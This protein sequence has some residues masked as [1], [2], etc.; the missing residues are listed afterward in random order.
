MGYTFQYQSLFFIR[1]EMGRPFE[2]DI[3]TAYA[4]RIRLHD[5]LNG[6]LH[7]FQAQPHVLCLDTHGSDHTG[8][9]GGGCQVSGGK[10]LPFSLVVRGGICLYSGPG[11][12]V[13]GNRS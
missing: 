6:Y 5:L 9:Q 3:D 2:R 13:R 4:A 8:R 12:L 1:L 10:T 11:L 7:A